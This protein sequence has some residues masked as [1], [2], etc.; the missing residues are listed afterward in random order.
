MI[1]QVLV[2]TNLLLFS[3]TVQAGVYVGATT[4]PEGVLFSQKSHVTRPGTFDVVDKQHLGGVG[5]FGSAFAGI[6]TIR[7][8]WSL[9]AEVN[10][11][12]SSVNYLLTNDEY[13]NG[14]SSKTRLSIHNSEGISILPGY[15]LG[16]ST[17]VYSRIGY[18]NAH[19]KIRESDPS[20]K[21]VTTDKAGIRYGLGIKHSLNTKWQL[22]MDYSQINFNSI[23]SRV[24]DPLGMVTKTT[25]ITPN[26]AQVG[27]G[28]IYNFDNVVSFS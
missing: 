4:G 17:L 26:T 27:V 19:L 15:F 8:Q 23:K 21:S 14:T 6:N 22:I 24:Y 3:I 20:I 1:R 7:N 13:I 5:I 16:S 25:K 11:N 2:T 18:T 10:A 28:L 12:L 9:A